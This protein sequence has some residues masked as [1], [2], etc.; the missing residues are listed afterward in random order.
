MM[1]ETNRSGDAEELRIFFVRVRQ[2]YPEL[3]SDAH[4]ISGNCDIAEYA[5]QKAI[6]DAWAQQQRGGGR[7]LGEYLRQQTL[8]QA[9][10]DA[11]HAED[12]EVTWDGLQGDLLEEEKDPVRAAVFAERTEMRRMLAMRYGCGMSARD[13]GR[14]LKMD[15]ARV[16]GALHRFETRLKRKLDSARRKR[17]DQVM[18]GAIRLELSRPDPAMPEIGSVYRTFEAEAC[19][20][21]QPNRAVMRAA[22]AAFTVFAAVLLVAAFWLTA[23]LLKGPTASPKPAPTLAPQTDWLAGE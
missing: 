17:F 20:V 6:S 1:Y 5:V 22:K 12:A 2:V 9:L 15:E 3:F 19:S 18:A 7:R 14:V 8:R 13:I 10:S 23:A 16:R 11:L 21:K 4:A